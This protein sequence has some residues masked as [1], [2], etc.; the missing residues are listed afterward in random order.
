MVG[1]APTEFPEKCIFPPLFTLQPNWT[2]SISCRSPQR[3]PLKTPCPLAGLAAFLLATGKAGR[4][5]SGFPILL[6]AALTTPSLATLTSLSCSTHRL[7][8]G[9]PQ[10]W[11]GRERHHAHRSRHLAALPFLAERCSRRRCC[12]ARFRRRFAVTL[13]RPPCCV[14]AATA[15]RRYSLRVACTFELRRRVVRRRGSRKSQQAATVRLRRR[16]AH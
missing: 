12:S 16:G 5:S 15:G 14:R 11:P 10:D 13:E 7:L 3:L 2:R 8:K 9:G 4:V 1:L 6:E